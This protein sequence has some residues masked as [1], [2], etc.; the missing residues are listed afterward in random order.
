MERLAGGFGR[1]ERLGRRA[2]SLGRH[3]VGDAGEDLVARV[4][5][6]AERG[7]CFGVGCEQLRKRSRTGEIL[8]YYNPQLSEEI[9]L[10]TRSRLGFTYLVSTHG[11]SGDVEC[12]RTK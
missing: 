1:R 4:G 7:D 9:M 10:N 11:R 2:G 12:F 8:H 5:V 3:V 6:F